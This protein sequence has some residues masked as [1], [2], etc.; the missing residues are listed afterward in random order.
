MSDE[1]ESAFADNDGNLYLACPQGIGKVT[2]YRANKIG[3]PK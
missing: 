3:L 1:V 2:N